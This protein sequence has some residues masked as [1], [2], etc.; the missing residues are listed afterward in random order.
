MTDVLK[1]GNGYVRMRN[2]Y[3]GESRLR[4]AMTV[5]EF[6]SYGRFEVGFEVQVNT[7]RGDGGIFNVR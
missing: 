1:G 2:R 6:E 7:V 3:G 5:D 4:V